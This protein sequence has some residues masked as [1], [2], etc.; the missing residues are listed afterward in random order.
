M[1]T[2]AAVM[3][4]IGKMS[5]REYDV[6]KPEEGQV[7]IK[8]HNC[9]I[10]TSDWQTWLGARKSQKRT[11]P[12][13]PG[14]E[15]AGEIAEIGPGVTEY[16][17]GDHVAIGY[18]GCGYCHA[19][20]TGKTS[21][22]PNTKSLVRAGISGGHGMSQYYT[23]TL[24]RVFKISDEL[25]YEE[26][27]YLEPLSTA[28]HGIRKLRVSPGDYLLVIG[29]GNLGLVNAQLARAFGCKVVVSEVDEKRCEIANS[30]GFTVINP[31]QE[32]LISETKKLSKGRGIDVVILAVGNTV[33]TDQALQVVKRCGKVLFFASSYPPAQINIDV[34]GLHYGNYEFIGTGG[35]DLTD[36]ELSAQLLSDGT[37]KCD[38]IVSH[39]VP[40]DDIQ[41]AFELASTPGNYR[42]SL[43]MWP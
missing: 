40:L 28:V 20:R 33:A 15:A 6:Q 22:C 14:H 37:V 12:W 30:L 1:K 38:K 26:A 32:D 2:K 4:D 25:A 13:A 10:C 19:C 42:V 18:P 8:V 29:A 43:V 31:T 41:K 9:N 21:K 17:T 3:E 5:I 39:K 27:C 11:F 24:N 36:Y 16:K 35:A 34:N 7:L 23:A